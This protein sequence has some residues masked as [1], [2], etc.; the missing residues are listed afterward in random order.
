M[1]VHYLSIAHMLFWRNRGR[2]GKGDI[3][4]KKG[5]VLGGGEWEG[6]KDGDV[7]RVENN[8]EDL[9]LAISP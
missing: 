5:K 4:D 6:E 9:P 7:R 1:C 2:N 3:E 8:S